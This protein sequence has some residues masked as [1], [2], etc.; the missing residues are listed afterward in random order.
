VLAFA[1]EEKTAGEPEANQVSWLGSVGD[2]DV[3]A[4]VDKCGL[5]HWQQALGAIGIRVDEVHSETLLLPVRPGEW[6]LAWNGSD[7]FIRTGEF[8]GA[9]TDCGNRESP[10]LFLR[11]MLE[12]VKARSAGPT[13]IALY[14]TNPD[15]APD[16]ATW[17]R[18]LGIGLRIAGAWDWRRAS[19]GAGISLVQQRQSWRI[20]SGAAMR[21]QP[22]A[23]IL[24]AALTMHAVALV[25][26]LTLLS[27]EQRALHQQMELQFRAAFPDAVAVV[28]PVLQMRRKLVEARHTAGLSDSGDFLP[29]IE[30]VEAAAKELPAATVRAVSYEGGRIT[31][32]LATSEE[33]AVHRI[34]AH[35]RQSGLNVDT[36]LTSTR[37]ANARVVLIVRAS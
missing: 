5:E 31:L 2:E 11:L 17:Q 28:D 8:E 25:I 32:E 37:A 10:P 33:V 12:E 21:L 4:V 36:S 9:A 16:I 1:V 13:S 3:L 15:A 14:M 26:G 7:G 35:L 34:M 6:S 24:G 23:W 20:F 29:M 18:E 30:K 22:A 19:S 27:G